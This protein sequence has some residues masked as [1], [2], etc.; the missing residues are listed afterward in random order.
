MKA[1][2]NDN[3]KEQIYVSKLTVA[4]VALVFEN[5]V[6][7]FHYFYFLRVPF[8]KQ[9]SVSG[10]FQWRIDELFNHLYFLLAQLHNLA[11]Y[12]LKQLL[13][14]DQIHFFSI[15][16]FIYSKM[17][18]DKVVHFFVFHHRQIFLALVQSFPKIY[19]QGLNREIHRLA[20]RYKQVI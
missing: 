1:L 2:A 6:E 9:I 8:F 4:D 13:K 18:F 10:E 12:L 17:I 15:G 5:L 11:V 7:L 14:L 3:P 20:S 19:Y 16:Q